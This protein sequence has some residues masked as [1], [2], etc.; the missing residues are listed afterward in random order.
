[1]RWVDGGVAG[2]GS[3]R[4]LTQIRRGVRE[5]GQ[6]GADGRA[7]PVYQAAQ[8][9]AA[10]WSRRRRMGRVLG[11]VSAVG[12]YHEA[13][14]SPVRFRGAGER[15]A[16]TCRRGFPGRYSVRRVDRSSLVVQWRR[17]RWA[18]G[19]ARLRWGVGGISCPGD[20][21][22]YRNLVRYRRRSVDDLAGQV[23]PIFR[24]KWPSL[25]VSEAPPR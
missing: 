3:R 16:P 24:K 5:S 6:A 12:R 2:S 20:G 17:V 9:R 1:V 11:F 14:D 21:R 15:A 19:S 7:G 25:T 4:H 18:W 8:R 23:T 10:A 13:V 22:R